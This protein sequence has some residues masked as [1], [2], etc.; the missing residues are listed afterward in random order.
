M[1]FD[2]KL[3]MYNA[4]LPYGPPNVAT[5]KI[6]FTYL[7]TLANVQELKP[8]LPSNEQLIAAVSPLCS[9]T[10]IRGVPI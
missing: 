2:E 10:S 6:Y 9:L 3:H 5:E 1:H 7:V 4:K 8:F